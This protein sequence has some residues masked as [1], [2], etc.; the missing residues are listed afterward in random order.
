[1]KTG[2]LQELSEQFV[3]DCTANPNDCGGT[4]GCGVCGCRVVVNALELP[5]IQKGRHGLAGHQH[6]RAKG[7]PC[8]GVLFVCVC[9][10]DTSRFK[11][12]Q[13]SEWTVR[14]AVRACTAARSRR[15][16]SILTSATTARTSPLATLPC[17]LP[18]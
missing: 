10:C 14:A 7:V 11:G 5:S 4:G 3:L 6:H 1:M 18:P 15:C 2:N 13:P 12:G 17:P 16:R 9:E 8:G